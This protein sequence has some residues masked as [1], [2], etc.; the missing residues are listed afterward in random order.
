VLH[1]EARLVRGYKPAMPSYEGL[2]SESDLDA[3]AEYI[4]TLK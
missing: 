4:R 1:P 3:L 2:L